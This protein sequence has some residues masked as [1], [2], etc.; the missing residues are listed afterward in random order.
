MSG[1]YIYIYVTIWKVQAISQK[2]NFLMGNYAAVHS[3]VIGGQQLP[4]IPKTFVRVYMSNFCWLT[5]KFSIVWC[6]LGLLQAS[7]ANITRFLMEIT[8]INFIYW[9]YLTVY[10]SLSHTGVW[11]CDWWVLRTHTY[12]KFTHKSLMMLF[13]MKIWYCLPTCLCRLQNFA[14]SFWA[15]ITDWKFHTLHCLGAELGRTKITL[16]WYHF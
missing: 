14:H 2:S 11:G 3:C 1:R 10:Q 5:I 12:Y 8:I 4:T 13:L 16:N 7:G 15:W 9:H 6:L